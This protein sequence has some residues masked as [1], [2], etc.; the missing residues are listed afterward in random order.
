MSRARDNRGL[1]TALFFAFF[2]VLMFAAV[3]RGNVFL[4]STDDNI[5]STQARQ[6]LLR[7]GWLTRWNDSELLGQ[8]DT[9][10]F[11]W[12]HLLLYIL[13]AR[14]FVNWIH[15]IDLALASAL[16]CALLRKLGI[17]PLAAVFGALTAL[18]VGSNFTLAYAGHI[19]KFEVLLWAACALWLIEIAVRRSSVPAGLLAGGAIGGM[20]QLQPDVALFF[21]MLI[22]PY[23]VYACWREN[24]FVPRAFIRTFAPMTLTAA[25][26]VLPV[27]L[28]QSRL[29]LSNVAATD[30][31]RPLEKWNF[32]T[33]WS[34]PPDETIDFV[35]PGYMGWRTGEPD[36]PYW[37][38]M[39]RSAGWEQ[40]RQGFMNFKLEN[41]YLG[42]MPIVFAMFAVAWA[43]RGSGFRV[44][45][46]DGEGGRRSVE[47]G[48][49]GRSTTPTHPRTH[50]PTPFRTRS[51]RRTAVVFWAAATLI[52][53]LLSFG[54]FF[55]LYALFYKLPVVNNIRNPNKFLQVF[56]L[57]LG[58]LAAYGIDIASKCA[59]RK[60]SGGSS[61]PAR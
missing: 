59:D 9:L 32:C 49:D 20:F 51:D 17:S 58:I 50:T 60:A 55:P 44:Q 40:T 36:G 6:S 11:C 16:L 8:Y 1:L 41:Q 15:A 47:G 29:N 38:Q 3:L 10:A 25:L 2:A 43:L 46:L 54:K 13:P 37:G 24:R 28:S 33:Q 22:G 56:Q 4:F 39:G 7:G 30:T 23:A 52:A 5:A 48:G 18:W 57:A 42:V 26:M 53:L 27:F 12:T 61:I 35:A 21:A 14:S 45:G 34:W 31:E 19:G